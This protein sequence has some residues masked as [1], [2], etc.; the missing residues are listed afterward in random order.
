MTA[1]RDRAARQHGF[2]FALGSAAAY[3]TNIVSAQIAGQAGLSGPLLVFYRVFLM[4]A[5]ASLVAL[6]WR[7]SLAVPR[8][9]RRAL[10][11]FGFAS[12]G[13]GCAYLSSVAFVPVSVAAVVF[14]TF[15]IL[16]ILAEPLLT[17]ARFSLDRLAVALL[18]FAGVAMVVGPDLHGLD[19]RGLML[20]LAASVLAATQFFAANASPTTPLLPRLFWSHLMI[21]PIAAGILVLMGGFLSPGALALAP[22][23]VAV[24]IGGYLIGFLLQ[25]LA[26]M[27][28]APG[29]AG[30]AFCAEP[31]FAVAVAALMLGERL[32][33][34]QYA[35]GALV[36]AAIMAN[37]ILEQNRRLL[38]PA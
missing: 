33:A 18:A 17:S 20:A 14:Y 30:L 10:A 27:R 25:V 22:G 7:A 29:N 35:G 13:V 31:V 15:P 36:V 16:I 26:L 38:A 32:G 24:T 4:L 3:G 2:L 8:G 23:A 6:L 5:L 19:P 11:L 37:V 28:V 34:L 1:D 12:A 21:L 9:E